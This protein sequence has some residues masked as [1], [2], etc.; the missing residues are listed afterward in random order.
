MP[1]PFVSAGSFALEDVELEDDEEL[2]DEALFAGGGPPPPGGGPPARGG[3]PLGAALAESVSAALLAFRLALS[4]AKVEIC[5]L[6]AGLL[7][8]AFAGV[9]A[10]CA[11]A[12]GASALLGLA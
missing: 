8:L 7:L 6:A 1:S 11:A 5:T 4:F 10:D 2:D 3:G 9:A 12:V